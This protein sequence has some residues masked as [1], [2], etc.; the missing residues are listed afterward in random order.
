MIRAT[1]L[2]QYFVFGSSF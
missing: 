2:K 1:F